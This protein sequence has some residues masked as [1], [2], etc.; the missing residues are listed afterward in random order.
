MIKEILDAP[1]EH[2]QSSGKFSIS[3]IGSCWRKKYLEMKGLHK[4]EYDEKTKR[5]FALGDAFHRH[6]VGELMSKCHKEWNVVACEVNI[7]A[8]PYI[9]GRCDLVLGN[10]VT[11]E[12]IILDTKSCSDWTFNKARE[13]TAPQNYINQ[14]QLY[15]HFFNLER[16]LIL[17][18]SKHKGEYC[19]VEIK[20]DVE[21][22]SRLMAEIKHFWEAHVLP[23]IEPEPCDGFKGGGMFPCPI[24]FKDIK[25]VEDGNTK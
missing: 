22:I 23:S 25:K 14:V 3:S 21:L 24:C 8:H 15:L 20:R 2:H 13:G 19:E 11:G 17:F 16:G 1:I 6:V 12:R 4:E 10:S 5:A 18:F 9:T 7:P